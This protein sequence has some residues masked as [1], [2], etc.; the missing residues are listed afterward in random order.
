MAASKIEKESSRP[1]YIRVLYF[2]PQTR[3]MKAGR[4]FLACPMRRQTTFLQGAAHA[5]RTQTLLTPF[6]RSCLDHSLLA[7]L[8]TGKINLKL[9]ETRTIM[10][11]PGLLVHRGNGAAE[12][13]IRLG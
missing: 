8:Q 4:D 2:E 12:N 10:L 7:G 5:E 11:P 6:L 13:H 9:M 3:V 1:A